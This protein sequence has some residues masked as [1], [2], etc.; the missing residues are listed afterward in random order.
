MYKLL[1]VSDREEVL[2]AFGEITNWEMLG[3]RQPHIRN[4]YDGMLDSLQKH[5]ADGIAIAMTEQNEENQIYAYLQQHYP[6]VSIFEAGTNQEE[7]IRYL[8]ELKTLLNRIRADFSNENFSEADILQQ[9]RHEFLRKV[10]AGKM[11]DQAEL[12]RYMHLLRS[13]M[14]ADRPCLVMDIEQSAVRDDRLEGRWPYGEQLLEG[15]LKKSFGGN[16]LGLHIFP[17]V[18]PDGR[19]V[20]LACPLHGEEKQLSEEEMKEE[21]TRHVTD[22]VLHLKEYNGLDL[23]ITGVRIMPALTAFCGS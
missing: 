14:D 13:K 10:M 16:Y 22:G 5:H 6:A 12:R 1:L 3:F 4:N 9:C 20:V 17:S 15:A 21:V 19:I 23:H 11:T 8:G 18:Y 2:K 7:I